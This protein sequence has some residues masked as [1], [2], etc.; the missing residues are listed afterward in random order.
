VISHRLTPLAGTDHILVLD[1]GRVVEE[2]SHG[3]LVARGGWYAR[4][5]QREQ[6]I[7]AASQPATA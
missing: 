7:A 4:T 2:G 5:W 3:A 1:G 6:E